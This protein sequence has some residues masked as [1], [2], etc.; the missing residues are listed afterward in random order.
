M[1]AQ[2][3]IFKSPG[4]TGFVHWQCEKT[5]ICLLANPSERFTSY[6]SAKA[7]HA[8]ASLLSVFAVSQVTKSCSLPCW[9][10]QQLRLLM[11]LVRMKTPDSRSCPQNSGSN[12]QSNRNRKNATPTATT[13]TTT[14]ATATTAAITTHFK[15]LNPSVNSVQKKRTTRKPY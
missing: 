8:L 7:G 10:S 11:W 2:L 5:H 1:W 12:S 4:V 15:Q 3:D 13:A 14:D 6:S 9:G